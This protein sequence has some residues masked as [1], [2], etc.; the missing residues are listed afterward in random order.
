MHLKGLTNLRELYL[1]GERSTITDAG[2]GHLMG[3][4]KLTRLWLNGTQVTDAGV[5]AL[6]QALPECEI[7]K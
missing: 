2:I 6:Q 5:V 1:G 4:A 3:L 7:V